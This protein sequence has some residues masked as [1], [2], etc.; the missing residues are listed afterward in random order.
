MKSLDSVYVDKAQTDI[1][2]VNVYLIKDNQA[3]KYT[4]LRK[5]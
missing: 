2:A 4:Y 5:A 3:N 1:Q